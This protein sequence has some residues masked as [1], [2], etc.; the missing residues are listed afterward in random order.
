[1]FEFHKRN[2]VIETT[3]QR[4]HTAYETCFLQVYVI[5][6]EDVPNLVTSKSDILAVGPYISYLW[7]QIVRINDQPI[8]VIFFVFEQT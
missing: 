2:I 6:E 8:R 4:S 5:G 1:M 3:N 7:V